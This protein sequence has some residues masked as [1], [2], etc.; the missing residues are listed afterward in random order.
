MSPTLRAVRSDDEVHAV[1]GP[2]LPIG[3]RIPLRG[4]G[5]TFVREVAGPP[6]APTILLLHGWIASGGLNWFTAFDALGA[7]YRVLALDQR[8][9][10]RGIRTRKRFTL[11]DCADDAAVLI[12]QLDIGPVIAVGYSL[13]GPVAQLL[14]R[15]HPDLVDGLVLCATSHHLMPGFREQMIFGSVMAAAAGSSRLGYLAARAPIKRMRQ[16]LPRTTPARPE[17]MREWAGAEMRRHDP[18]HLLEAG[19]AMSSYHAKW[20]DKVDVPTAVLVTT[21]D[22]AVNPFAQLAMALRIPEASIHRIEDGHV[23]CSKPSFAPALSAAVADVV[24]R[25]YPPQ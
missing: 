18:R 12:E 21:K 22:K 23:V 8:G 13:G 19:W 14:W 4:R 10:G 20:I 15:R 2:P 24:A 11:A 17:T 16:W 6:G 7:D 1:G 5:T 9:H 25:A 3:Q